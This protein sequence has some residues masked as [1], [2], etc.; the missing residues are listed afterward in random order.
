MQKQEQEIVEK[1]IKKDSRKG[2]SEKPTQVPLPKPFEVTEKIDSTESMMNDFVESEKTVFEEEK[3]PEMGNGV[4]EE[5]KYLFDLSKTKKTH[6]RAPR[7][8]DNKKPTSFTKVSLPKISTPPSDFKIEGFNIEKTAETIA[9]KIKFETEIERGR[10]EADANKW[11]KF[12]EKSKEE[13]AILLD[14]LYLMSAVPKDV[15]S[16]RSGRYTKD[17]LWN[18]VKF[19]LSRSYD[20]SDAQLDSF[21]DKLFS[22]I[23]AQMKTNPLYLH[24]I[25]DLIYGICNNDINQNTFE[26]INSMTMDEKKIVLISILKPLESWGVEDWLNNFNRYFKECFNDDVTID[27]FETLEKSTLLLKDGA[28]DQTRYEMVSYLP[29]IS[30][31]LKENMRKSIGI[32]L[33]QI[34]DAINDIEEEIKLEEEVERGRVETDIE[35]WKDAINRL[36]EEDFVLVDM[37]Y[38]VASTYR[39]KSNVGKHYLINHLWDAVKENMKL[40]YELTDEHFIRYKEILYSHIQKELNTNLL[41]L[42]RNEKIIYGPIKDDLIEHIVNNVENMGDVDKKAILCYLY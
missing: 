27:V 32:D 1:M 12:A 31:E 3:T 15:N 14:L 16:V 10:V 20:I 35:K 34:E 4:D 5:T 37:L 11:T 26:V 18:A 28:N 41:H 19:N 40:R 25:E 22:E 24:E 39:F 29:N 7:L 17:H 23:R 36:K 13:N 9:E 21:G 38:T 8:I 2:L 6:I 33:S 42:F 30:N